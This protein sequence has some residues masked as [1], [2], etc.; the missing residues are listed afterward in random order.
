MNKHLYRLIFNKAR[1]LIMAVAETASSYSKALGHT[2]AA[3]TAVVKQEVAGVSPLRFGIWLALGMVAYV[4]PASA[5]IVVD[6][7]APADQHPT[8]LTAANGVTQ[9]NIQTA[10]AGGVSR[11]SYSEFDVDKE[12]VILNNSRTHTQ[13][14]LGGWVQANPWLANREAKIILNEVNS[15][16]PSQLLGYIEVA[17]GKAQV[18]IA[19]G[20]GITC[21]GCGFINASQATLTTGT[22]N[23]VNGNLDSYNVDKGIIRIE[24]AGLDT[25]QTDYTALMARAVEVNAGIW[26]NKLDVI[27]GANQI[28]AA[29]STTTTTANTGTSPAFAV[30][31][32]ALGGMYAGQIRLVGT[33]AGVGVR[34]AGTLGASAGSVVVT[35]D[36]I[37][38]NTGNVTATAQVQIDTQNHIQ[39]SGTL[40]AQGDTSLN[41]KGTINNAGVIAAKGNTSLT[42]DGAN[43]NITSAQGSVLGAG[44]QVDGALGS[45]GN[46]TLAATK[47]IKVQGKS[48]SGDDQIFT[49]KTLDLSG[50]DNSA[51]NL[52]LTAIEGD[53]TLTGATLATS[54]T[55]TANTTQTLRTDQAKVSALQLAL[56]ARNLINVQ[57]ELAQ[58]GDGDLALHLAGTLNNDQG[59]IAT[60]SQ[61]LSIKAAAVTNASGKLEH[62]GSG[63]LSLETGTLNNLAGTVSSNGLL[64]IKAASTLSDKGS[65]S[66]EQL[67]IDSTIFSNRAGTIT[68]RGSNATQITAATQFDNASGSLVSKGATTITI[69]SL[70]NQGGKIQV[71]TETSAADLTIAATGDIENSGQQGARGTIT[72]TGNTTIAAESLHNSEGNITAAKS[73]AATTTKTLTNE[74][75]VLVGNERVAIQASAIENTHGTIGS[76]A[77]EVKVTATQ[78]K[79]NNT[80]GRIEAA[81]AVTVSVVGVN[82]NKGVIT[83]SSIAA[84][85]QLDLFDNTQGA[86]TSTSDALDL[87]TG[88]LLNDAGLIQA[89]GQLSINTHEQAL[90]NT[91][92]S[93]L[94][95]D[96]NPLGIL[97]LGAVNLTTGLLD[98]S[99]GYIGSLGAL[100]A[101]SSAV[102]NTQGG[103][104][105]SANTLSLKGNTLD[106]QGG[107][108]QALG[109]TT[110]TFGESIDNRGSLIRTNNHLSISA[111]SLNNANTLQTA[112]GES[113]IQKDAGIDA[114]A[115]DLAA[116]QVINSQG[117]LRADTDLTLLSQGV[118]ENTQGLMSAGA[119]ATL[120]DTASTGRTLQVNNSGGTLI[121]GQSLNVDSAGLAG[122][123]NVL[124]EGDLV[125]SFV[126]DYS[127]TT[128]FQ[129]NGSASLT[130][131]GTFTNLSSLLAGN[132]LTL[133]ATTIENQANADISAQQLS[134]SASD[135]LNNR[136]LINGSDTFINTTNLNNLGT[137]RIYGDHIA[138]KAVTLTN[139][140]ETT[141]TG[142]SKA[143]VIAARERLDIGAQTINNR[144]HALLFSLK[145]IAIGGSLDTAT[146]TTTGQAHVLNNE[147]A[148]IEAL[149]ALDLSAQH[150][151]NINTHITEIIDITNTEKIVEYEGIISNRGVGKKYREGTPGV[152]IVNH[153][154]DYLHTP[155]QEYQ[156]WQAYRYTS[157]V[158]EQQ[159]I[160]VAPARI[161][162]Q[163]AI[164]FNANVIRNL[165]STIIAGGDINTTVAAENLT[166]TQ[167]DVTRTTTHIGTL[168]DYYRNFNSGRDSTGHHGP[169]LW[170]P[171]PT[172]EIIRLVPTAGYEDNKTHTGSDTQVA[173]LNT[174]TVTATPENTLV[175]KVN[176]T[177]AAPINL[178]SEIPLVTASASEANPQ[179][180]RT[181]GVNTQ[182]PNNSLYRLNP[183]PNASYLVETDPAFTSN[184]L[185]LSSDYMLNALA[186]DPAITQTRLG[187]GF[188][189]QQL[190]REQIALL[191]GRRFLEGYSDDEAQYRAL[192]D[193]AATYV[194]DYNLRPGVALSAEQMAALTSDIVWLVE[195]P[196]TLADGTATHVLVPQVYV[197]VGKGDIDGTGALISGES[198]DLKLTG[199]LGNSGTLA[200]RKVVKL[201]AE[202][203]EN[204]GGRISAATLNLK[205]RQDLLNIGGTLDADDSMTLEAGQ[206]IKVSSTTTTGTSAQGSRTRV[207]RVAGLYVTGTHNNG[208]LV[209]LAGG[210]ILLEAAQVINQTSPGTD[211]NSSGHTRLSAGNN[212]NIN[213][214][215]ESENQTINTSRGSLTSTGSRYETRS[216]QE[217]GSHI[218]TDG[219]LEISAGN[220][221]GIKASD[222]NATSNITLDAKN[223]INLTAVA[224][225]QHDESND[226]KHS[227]VNTIVEHSL[228]GITS[229]GDV[230]L[231][232][233]NDANLTGTA[234]TSA[235]D[236]SIAA[237][238][239][240]NISAVVDSEYHY[241]KDT[242][243]KSFGRSKTTT[244][245]T[246]DEKLAGGTVES[247]GD[248][249][250][251]AHK[252][253]EGKVIGDESG[254]VNLAGVSLNAKDDVAIAADED[255]NI[256]GMH[257]E[258][259]NYQQTKKSGSL[260]INKK[261]K[262]AVQNDSH[263]Q[264]AQIEA[265]GNAHILSGQDITL[266]A[267]NVVVKGNIDMQAVDNLLVTAGEAIHNSEEWNK[268]SGMFS[269]GDLYRKSEHKAGEGITEAQASNL[270]AG[271]TVNAHAGTG[272]I[273]GSNIKGDKGVKLVSDAG[274]FDILAATTTTQAYSHDKTMSVGAGDLGKAISR[275][276][277]MVKNQDGRATVKIAD[278]Q[279]DSEDKKSSAKDQLGSNIESQQHVTVIASAGKVKMQ[280]STVAAD[281]DGNQDGTLGMA[282]ATGI[283]IDEATNS[284]ESETKTVHGSA[285]LSVVVQHQAVEVVKAALA[286]DKAK[287]QLEK[288][289]KEFKAYERNLD[290]LQTQLG[291][292]ESDYNN[293]V[294]GIAYAD[295][296][297]LR[298]I[299]SDSKDDKEWYQAGVA[300]AATNLASSITAL[301]QQ[302]VAAVQST[303]TYG[304]NAGVQL[305]IDASKSTSKNNSTTAQASNLSGHNIVM[306][307]GT[308]TADGSLNREGTTTNIKGSHL[309]ARNQ[310]DIHTGELNLLNSTDTTEQKN[311]NEHG[312]ITAQMTVY[313]ASGGVSVSGS[314]DRSKD[315]NTTSTVNNTTLNADKIN[316]STLGDA[317]LRGAN[318]HADSAL[319]ADV[320][321][322]LNVESQQN[323]SRSKNNSAGIS[324]GF[325][326]GGKADDGTSPTAKTSRTGGNAFTNNLQGTG[327]VAGASG[328][329]GGIHASNGMSLTRET[330]LT[331]L[332]SGGTADINVKGN[333]QITGALIATIDT[334]GKDTNQLNLDTKTLTFTDLRNTNISN[335][336]S[337]GISTNLGIN[338]NAK[339]TDKN[340]SNTATTA[341]GDQLRAQT[342][343]LTYNNTQTNS[344]SK[345]L[346]TLGHGNITVGGT[347]MERN[348]EL[349]D[350]GKASNSPLILLN[351]DT[352]NTEK[353]LWNSEQSQTVDATLD[354]RLL[355]AEGHQQIK[356]DVKR[357][358]IGI[359]SIANLADQSVSFLGNGEGETSLRQHMQDS[360]DYFTATKNFAND[361]N[362]KQYI[363]VINSGTGTPEQKDAAYTALA[364]SVAA[365]MGVDPIKAMPLVQDHY[366]LNTQHYEGTSIQQQIQG[367]YASDPAATSGKKNGLIFMVDDNIANTSDAVNILGHETSHHLDANRNPDAVKTQAYQENRESYADI[368]GAA[369]VDYVNFNFASN[370]YTAL[371]AVNQ[372]T[373]STTLN[374]TVRQ[375]NATFNALD[376]NRVDYRQL[377]IPE[378][379]YVRDEK[380]VERFA[381]YIKS[382]TGEE[383]SSKEAQARLL[384]GSAGLMD[385]KWQEQYGTDAKV[386]DFLTSEVAADIKA[387]GSS[388]VGN[389]K[390]EMAELSLQQQLM[391][392]NL[393]YVDPKTG[394]K[395]VVFA[396][397]QSDYTNE[398]KGVVDFM[399]NQT[400]GLIDALGVAKTDQQRRNDFWIGHTQGQ[401]AAL[402]HPIDMTLAGIANSASGLLNFISSPIDTTQAA[403]QDF[404]EADAYG[405]MLSFQGRDQDLGYLEG[406]SQ[407]AMA[408]S[409]VAAP[410]MEAIGGSLLQGALARAN[411]GTVEIMT[412]AKGQATGI[413]IQ[414]RAA[415]PNWDTASSR[416]EG[417]FG[418][419]NQTVKFESTDTDDASRI[420]NGTRMD[421]RLPDPLAGWDYVP[422]TLD[423][424]NPNIANSQINGFNG[425]LNL[426][427]KIA[428]LPNQVV[429]SY[430]DKVGTHGADIISV[431]SVTGEVT[432]WDNKFR[433]NPGNIQQSPTFKEGSNRLNEAIEEARIAIIMSD[434][435]ENI[436]QE[437]LK[438]IRSGN[439]I[440]NTVGD[441][442]SKNSHHLAYCGYKPCGE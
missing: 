313:G 223:D 110:L 360:Q 189:E 331:S 335:Q 131:T 2:S 30:D 34:N 367:A 53:I 152:Y 12:G 200:G 269:G 308:A 175:A 46:L 151:N 358:E 352:T 39:N 359:E 196:V 321:G 296:L 224:N 320:G 353:T 403:W 10:T 349:T 25:R 265:G 420:I 361:A 235:G 436:K 122:D 159:L 276:D 392:S 102:N 174:G 168:T 125:L 187:D 414:E 154:S 354:H 307:T 192:M 273:I 65:L 433:N 178:I 251:N 170:A 186:V 98:N 32:S 99:T 388:Q 42:S 421:S 106:N 24:G 40:Y 157:V 427:N 217:V 78:G 100:T 282:A 328:V 364:N 62:A 365:Q 22:P 23:L 41:S 227:F 93:S 226:K 291:Q 117:A 38:E 305:D 293:K 355:T 409:V 94:Q 247:G 422:K 20:S 339:A 372:R 37:I 382:T 426:A 393:A 410:A 45:S 139:D 67:R 59:R 373:G 144:E 13:T 375:N 105:T 231:N 74:Q 383:L 61:N 56:N 220:D 96:E 31:V 281:T 377:A 248:L 348:G 50:N 182:L 300:L 237:K 221:L 119:I 304:F 268:K 28:D 338:G 171:G 51:D 86:I 428:A 318:V 1:G 141:K 95:A 43:S 66:A 215:T 9:V 306:Q 195:T 391:D 405:R 435:P 368:M 232:A 423:S 81:Q 229:G 107:Q 295:L 310:I 165:D 284:Y 127:N 162:A 199:D 72:A 370:D 342:S 92:S 214:L 390:D 387:V 234:I 153:E 87:Q 179:V 177:Q 239:D 114:Q 75:G 430:G 44:V 397:A 143:A 264:N 112:A 336:T 385:G 378:I 371:G 329:N 47:A 146:H 191:T 181:G 277:Q 429:V 147:S 283:Y 213:S 8:V 394:E 222:L 259:L 167:T 415:T 132:A 366:S 228:V 250:I 219:D 137:G 101:E 258:T 111:A 254:T 210:D 261:D 236:T 172:N 396:L 118:V 286:V 176:I 399:S 97:G 413:S 278:A 88:A 80:A 71:G 169:F 158:T 241:S 63:E 266:A 287:E 357:T 52:T 312:H 183:G 173:A 133:N 330:V 418:Y 166:S 73:L 398:G 280:G 369:T 193:N 327:N 274:D 35:A 29:Q 417:D 91:H 7:S 384:Q 314:F 27:A 201:D 350:A 333:T 374:N 271:G 315:S 440:T 240:T 57:G 4:M 190:I 346:A 438:N 263:L 395:R 113:K 292:L 362:N 108:I 285:E 404:K 11:N 209:A 319:I 149:G 252:N 161:S 203:I 103:T 123:G 244:T 402:D 376:Q 441:G 416:V 311:E 424:A 211:E 49:A 233:G 419:L 17:G 275:P 412:D 130:T 82:N 121:A 126:G 290:Q 288:A 48:L 142:E 55:L 401:E 6:K 262:G 16:N 135:T 64:D 256:T 267:T 379:Q 188:Y 301:V 164:S 36:G 302:T 341:D 380:R 345:T 272:Q 351:R 180:V 245:E 434:L 230:S 323:R 337:A 79:L 242:D 68:Q 194:Q 411:G 33:E 389:T 253:A 202:N 185:W 129:A 442:S 205:A 138:I 297:E 140:V 85:S 77:N 332:T 104:I 207:D 356:E 326:L 386:M 347:E 218:A 437:S 3:R 325:S 216:H 425:E 431:D 76:L 116:T 343:N 225:E 163:G 148:G 156:Q 303:G 120:K 198:I 206:D 299:I 54:H 89:Q 21:A 407:G 270:V 324:G 212:I 322:D 90:T 58:V 134:L 317:N 26:A 150:I 255:V 60:N 439:Y 84:N 432:L 344:G 238:R 145:D 136:G 208:I 363:D 298:E 115:I 243:K 340:A 83:G 128:K 15:S 14:Q 381:G 334:K 204:L 257:Y 184:R 260:G 408:I 309:T 18:I 19:N 5:D 69:G 406:Y 197:R 70:A 400:L 249:L 160:T 294:P 316:L 279:F 124:S 246:L 289:K 155:E 109:D